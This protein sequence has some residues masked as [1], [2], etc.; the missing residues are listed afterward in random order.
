MPRQKDQN[1]S[2]ATS[3]CPIT[4]VHSYANLKTLRQVWADEIPTSPDRGNLPPTPKS[5]PQASH[6]AFREQPLTPTPLKRG[7]SDEDMM[8]PSQKRLKIMS[9]HPDFSCD[10]VSTPQFVRS[11]MQYDPEKE[12][13]QTPQRVRSQRSFTIPAHSQSSTA[14]SLS[15]ESI[16]RE[17]I[18]AD[19]VEEMVQ[20]LSGLPAYIR[21]LERR[22][23]AAEKSRD[24]KANKIQA[25]EAEVERCVLP[26]IY[27]FVIVTDI[28]ED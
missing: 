15:Q 16:S 14:P 8:T 23:I 17:E 4:T 3:V 9:E 28:A 10:S 21:K 7:L 6:S 1:A 19:S 22:K 20:S 27:L 5:N 11:Q 2:V 26:V 25:L 18:T 13:P 24:A 12:M